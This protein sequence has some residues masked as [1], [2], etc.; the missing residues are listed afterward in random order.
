MHCFCSDLLAVTHLKKQVSS[1]HRTSAESSKESNIPTNFIKQTVPENNGVWSDM[2]TLRFRLRRV[3]SLF[4]RERNWDRGL[5]S[6][7]FQIR[8]LVF[9]GIVCSE[10]LWTAPP[11]TS[12]KWS[13]VGRSAGCMKLHRKLYRLMH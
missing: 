3:W 11:Y 8:D 9:D 13:S 1:E 10:Y 12:F 4:L 2:Q 6:T 5:K 7:A